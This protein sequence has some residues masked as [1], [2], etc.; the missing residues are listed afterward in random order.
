MRS[1]SPETIAKIKAF[2]FNY[3]RANGRS[4]TVREVAE[5]VS[6]SVSVAQKYLVWLKENNQIEYSG[7]RGIS[8]EETEQFTGN[9]VPVGIIGKIN[10][11][12]P[13]SEEE[14]CEEYVRLP[15][16]LVGKGTFYILK[17][18]GDS[19][20]DAGIDDGDLVLVRQQKEAAPGQIVVALRNGEST[21][22]RYMVNSEGNIYLH[23]E[24]P[25][26]SDIVI[27]SNDELRIQGMAVKVIKDLEKV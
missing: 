20:T 11:G 15:E 17:A 24:N 25:A 27:G 13:E 19:M 8:M 22:K 1:K 4:P 23:P 5:A 18:S 26:H 14:R 21:L 12:L 7:R 10:Y 3:Y 6:I 2:I 16:K 9:M